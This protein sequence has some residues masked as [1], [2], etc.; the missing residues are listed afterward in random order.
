M[1]STPYA[2]APTSH[3]AR[4]TSVS[5][6][7][8]VG[9]LMTLGSLYDELTH[10]SMRSHSRRPVAK[11]RRPGPSGIPIN[12]RAMDVRSDIR[13]VLASWAAM[14]CEHHRIDAPAHDATAL[15]AFLVRHAEWLAGHEAAED[16]AAETD[17]MVRA[18]WSVLSDCRDGGTV[19]IGT[20]VH[21]D[22]GGQ[23]VAH[24]ASRTPSGTVA[25][26]CSADTSHTWSPDTW[27][28]LSSYRPPAGRSTGLTAQDISVGWRIAS[29]TVYWLANT[30]QWR[31]RKDGRRVLYDRDDVLTTMRSRD[32]ITSAT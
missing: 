13:S 30:H 31:R 17:E 12:T 21:P 10:P 4:S 6:R 32:T 2:S 3:A 7:Q 24:L 1:L 26:V 28:T 20:C 16:I 29:G 22:C 23:L 14:V 11:L 15:T 8:I 25:I 5:R 27:H 19:P 9:N 18:A